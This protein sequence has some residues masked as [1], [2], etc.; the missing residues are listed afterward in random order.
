[1]GTKHLIEKHGIQDLFFTRVSKKE[2]LLDNHIKDNHGSNNK[3]AREFSKVLKSA[4]S[5]K[6]F[7]TLFV[8]SEEVKQLSYFQILT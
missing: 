5:N 2:M 6:D 4:A 1:M 7:E 3:A 8:K